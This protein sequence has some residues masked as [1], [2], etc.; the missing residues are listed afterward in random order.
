MLMEPVMEK[1]YAMRMGAMVAAWQQ[2]QEDGSIGELSFDERF[3]LLVEAEHLARDKRRLSRLLRQADLRF[4]DACIEDVKTS[5][6]RGIDRATVRQL[7]SGAWI[8]Q[9]LNVLITGMTGVGKSY[10]ACA[11][12][13]AACRRGLRVLYR[14]TPRLFDELALAK[15]DGTYAKALGKLAK[16]EV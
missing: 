16:T 2:Q 5:S 11:L 12:G 9:H 14:R 1:L 6:A 15:A 3:A 13:Q 7:A 4:Q 8:D 10:L